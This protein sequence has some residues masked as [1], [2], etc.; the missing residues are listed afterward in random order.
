MDALKN[1]AMGSVLAELQGVSTWLGKMTSNIPFLKSDL[2]GLLNRNIG[3]ILD[4]PKLMDTSLGRMDPKNIAAPLSLQDLKR[5][6]GA[7]AIVYGA[8]AHT[9]TVPFVL[10]L[11]ASDTLNFNDG[12]LA[13]VRYN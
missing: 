6:E 3:P 5:G 2:G 9:L 12:F 1:I 4:L 7:A 8:T 10:K 13:T 11:S